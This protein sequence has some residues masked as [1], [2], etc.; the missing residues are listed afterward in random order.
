MTTAEARERKRQRTAGYIRLDLNRLAWERSEIQAE[1]QRVTDI[2]ARHLER[3]KKLA[4]K[5]TE[6]MR[7]L[8]AKAEAELTPRP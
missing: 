1:Y 6:A 3:L 4:A 7:R 2:Y 5:N 8:Y